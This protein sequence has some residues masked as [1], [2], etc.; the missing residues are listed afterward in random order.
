MLV[1]APASS[2]VLVPLL[3]LVWGPWLPSRAVVHVGTASVEYGSLSL[4]LVGA[5]SLAAVAFIIGGATARGFLKESHWFQTGKSI[6]VGIEAGGFGLIG[7]AVASILAIVG[8][9][10]YE[11][12][13]DSVGWG[14]L[15]FVFL[16]IAAICV[17]VAFLPRAQIETLT[18]EDSSR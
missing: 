16:F 7:F 13:S 2:I 3:Y 11:A 6:A 1:V 8:V 10:P 9:V 14:L 12:S 17:Y 5:C 4:L 18:T 15:C